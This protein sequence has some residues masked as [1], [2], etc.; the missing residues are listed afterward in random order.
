MPN[1]QRRKPL[2]HCGYLGVVRMSPRSYAGLVGA[3]RSSTL[4][5]AV[6]AGAVG[7]AFAVLPK[8]QLTYKAAVAT[9]FADESPGYAP[10]LSVTEGH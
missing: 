10:V 7:F 6:I 2:P 5:A 9:S 8:L 4:T 1:S 3:V